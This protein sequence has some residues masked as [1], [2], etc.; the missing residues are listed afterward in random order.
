MKDDINLMSLI[1]GV[2]GAFFRSIM[3]NLPKKETIINMFFGALIAQFLL[4]VIILFQFKFN[5]QIITLIVTIGGYISKDFLI[6]ARNVVSDIYDM[7]KFSL[8][9]LLNNITDRFKKK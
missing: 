3:D 9:Q 1:F 6:K 8:S 7:F 5:W 4:G 2:V